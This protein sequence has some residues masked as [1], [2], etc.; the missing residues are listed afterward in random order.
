MTRTTRRRART[1]GALAVALLLPL[2]AACGQGS[3]GPGSGGQ[4][5]GGQ[6]SGGQGSGGAPAGSSATA[7]SEPPASSV[8]GTATTPAPHGVLTGVP[9]YWLGTPSGSDRPWLYREFRDVPDVGG[10]GDVGGDDPAAARAASAVAAMTRDAPLDPDH[11]TPW[12]PASRVAVTR[13][14]DALAVD[15]S[16]DALAGTGV[17][18]QVAALAVQQLVHTATAAAQTTGPVTVTV[19]GAAADAWGAVRLG[20]PV[21]RAAPADVQAPVWVVEPQQGTH[22]V[23]GVVGITGVGTAFE[24]TLLW[25]VTGPA[26]EVFGEGSTTAGANGAF[27]EFSVGLADLPSGGPYAV[28]VWAP[29]ESGGES[30]LG[31]R[32]FVDTEEFWID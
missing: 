12:A 9:V 16:A 19:D 30:G 4:G 8:D 7:S 17:G 25:E 3:G 2:L 22:L 31:P 18:S 5:S 27:G 26:G 32:P 23:P 1:G 13:D 6:G 21:Q 28:S 11:T 24:G 20:E 14:G 15:L 29:D 10:V